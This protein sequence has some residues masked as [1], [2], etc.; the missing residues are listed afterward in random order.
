MKP[1]KIYQSKKGGFGEEQICFIFSNNIVVAV[2]M[3]S[4]LVL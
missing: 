1:V 2:A 4:L 3:D